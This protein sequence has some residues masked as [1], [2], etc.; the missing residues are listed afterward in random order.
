[1][2][3]NATGWYVYDDT[4][5]FVV[6][7]GGNVGIGTKNPANKL[8][9][10]GSGPV[11]IENPSGEADILFKSGSNKPWQVGTNAFGWYVW[12]GAYRFLVTPNGDVGI[13]TKEPLRTL[14]VEGREIHSG[15]TFG[16]FSFSNRS[17]PAFVENPSAG[18]RWLWYSVNGQARLWSGK[19]ALEVHARGGTFLLRIHGS[20]ETAV[21]EL[22][23]VVPDGLEAEPATI[24][25]RAKAIAVED[26]ASP[27]TTPGPPASLSSA[28]KSLQEPPPPPIPQPTTPVPPRI[29]LFHE[30]AKD[31][32][33]SL[34]INH[35]SRYKDGVRMEGNVHV[36]G[37]FTHASSIALKEDIAKLSGPEA[38]TT[39]RG[40]NA[41]KFSY[42]SDQRKQQHFGFI[43][44]ELPDI[45]AT[46]D[47]D[48]FSPM[49]VIAVLTKAV[50]E[51]SAEVQILKEQL[52]GAH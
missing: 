22:R 4:Y 5:R 11:T 21:S 16:G 12:D 40:L 34:V 29:A 37:A 6:I 18:E 39:L 8:H 47:R 46:A 15:G 26:P 1:V 20:L 48:R 3:T 30:F 13:G 33:D 7:P 10:V 9:V 14:H 32:K 41:V 45:L 42:K 35:Q 31:Q 52:R 27:V 44:E 17:N 38:M 28:A 19:D 36:T 2:G 23:G 25:C 51:L 24:R 43:A 50:Q 49:D